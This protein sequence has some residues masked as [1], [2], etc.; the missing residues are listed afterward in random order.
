MSPVD[1]RAYTTSGRLFS[2]YLN[3]IEVYS[4][5]FNTH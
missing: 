2:G 4:K 5:V 1:V 3:C